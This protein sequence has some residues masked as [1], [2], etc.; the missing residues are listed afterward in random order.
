MLSIITLICLFCCVIPASIGNI[1]AYPV[2]KKISLRISKYITKVC[3]P[4]V[5]AIL[6]TYRHFNF[7][8]YKKSKEGLP[9]QFIAISNHQSLLDIPVFMNFFREKNLRFVAKDTLG[10]HIPLVSEMLRSQ[11]HCLIPRRASPVTAMKTIEDFAKR[12]LSRNQIP[13]LFPEGS[14]TR[15]GNVGKF[16]SAGFRKLAEAT[17]LPVVVCALDGVW[18]IGRLRTIM[19]NLKNGNYKVTIVKIY[20]APKTKEAQNAILEEAPRLIQTKRAER[21]GLSVIEK[22]I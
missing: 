5:F 2:S 15:D 16:Y 20:D 10:R 7:W 6:K 19:T 17:A 21:S 9:Q 8:G 13:V 12:V 3:A 11:E 18:E 1:I 22:I 4:R 14:R